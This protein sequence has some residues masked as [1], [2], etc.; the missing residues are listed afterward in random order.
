MIEKKLRQEIAKIA[1]KNWQVELSDVVLVSPKELWQG[2]LTTNVALKVAARWGVPSSQVADI[3]IGE[4]VQAKFI[5]KNF[6]KVNAAGPGFVNFF[7]APQT[8]YDT[9]KMGLSNSTSPEWRGKKVLVEYSS[10]N[11]A[12]PMHVGHLRTTIIG[13]ALVNLYQALGAKVL[14][15][16]YLGDW[17]TQFGKLLVAY[18][19]WGSKVSL[20]HNPINEMLRV[21]VKFHEQAKKDPELDKQAQVAFQQLEKGNAALMGKWKLFKQYSLV[22]FKSL[23]KRLGVKFNHWEG[24][25]MYQ[26]LLKVVIKD[27]VTKKVATVN[28][29]GSIVVLFNDSKTPPMLVQKSDGASLYA[30]RDLAALRSRVKKYRPHLMLYVVGGE[31]SLYF[32]QL[33]SV[34][35]ITGY[36]GIT[37][38]KHIKFGFIFG[39]DGN[40]MATREG[41][42]IKLEE[43]FNQAI[44]L[45]WRVIQK[46]SPQLL[47]HE[48]A[49]V[50]EAVGVGAVKYN[51]LSQNRLTDIIFDWKKMLSFDG[52]SG[53]YLQYTYVRLKSI[54]R[55]AGKIKLLKFKVESLGDEDLDLLRKLAQFK[56]ALERAAQENG[57]HLVAGYLYELANAV[58]S[59]YHESPVLK[60]LEPVRSNRLKLV[61]Q[62]A[63]TLKLGLAILGMQV[64]ERM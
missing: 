7:M 20:K 58:N 30:T 63:E 42:I 59:Y 6:T 39:A 31:Q 44:D 48:K 29:D 60:A 4:L 12:K 54:L 28:E 52:N 64:V 13:Q 62:A 36:A 5:K 19:K 17:G 47:A 16:N 32:D 9:V 23:Y 34:S 41:K 45:A 51:D 22:E 2:D 25:S 38:I 14:A 24:E 46:K 56:N 57:P 3:I 21:Y 43:I 11:I 61:E 35:K 37:N 55:K 26:S 8:I 15:V 53:P 49:K 18:D 10:P 1:K 27:L 50:A 33:L 40:K